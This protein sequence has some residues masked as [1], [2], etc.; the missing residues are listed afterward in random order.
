MQTSSYSVMETSNDS[1]L[2][3]D[4]AFEQSQCEIANGAVTGQTAEPQIRDGGLC[5][6]GN[7]TTVK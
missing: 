5:E 7:K 6:A 2:R 1:I 4:T 3:H